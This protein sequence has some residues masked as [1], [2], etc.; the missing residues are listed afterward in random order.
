MDD[1]DDAVHRPGRDPSCP[2][3]AV[4][5]ARGAGL[6]DCPCFVIA[7]VSNE[8]APD[9]CAL[10]AFVI[11]EVMRSPWIAPHAAFAEFGVSGLSRGW[12]CPIGQFDPL[13]SPSAPEASVS[14]S[15]VPAFL[16]EQQRWC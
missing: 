14:P 4:S 1:A 11:A 5:S 9:L 10:L 13:D 6:R 16:A 8:P 15:L 3:G 12:C 7:A 2:R